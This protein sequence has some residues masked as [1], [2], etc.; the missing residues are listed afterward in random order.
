[1]AGSGDHSSAASDSLHPFRVGQVPVGYPNVGQERAQRLEKVTGVMRSGN[2]GR[3]EATIQDSIIR[4]NRRF[5][6]DAATAYAVLALKR[7]N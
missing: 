4:M 1:M 7:T 6:S 2:Q 5:M 3:T